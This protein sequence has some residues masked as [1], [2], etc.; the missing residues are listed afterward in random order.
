MP[1]PSTSQYT[2]AAASERRAGWG[3]EAG[4]MTPTLTLRTSWGSLHHQ[5]RTMQPEPASTP[6]HLSTKTWGQ[7]LPYWYHMYAVIWRT[8]TLCT[9]LEEANFRCTNKYQQRK[10]SNKRESSWI[11]SIF[12][13][14]E[15]H[16]A[17]A[18]TARARRAMSAPLTEQRRSQLGHKGP[19]SAHLTEQRRWQC[20]HAAGSTQGIT[21]ALERQ[22]SKKTQQHNQESK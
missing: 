12:Q 18:C 22:Q 8:I 13:N 2:V 16:R 21:S 15:P 14:S 7:L 6:I 20:G 19:T 5:D 9:A 4:S 3:G 10:K 17:E 1:G 11:T